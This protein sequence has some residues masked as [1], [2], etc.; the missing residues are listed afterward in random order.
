M[1]EVLEYVDITALHCKDENHLHPY[2]EQ[3]LQSPWLNQFVLVM[4][5][6]PKYHQCFHLDSA[7]Q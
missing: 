1:N 6:A 5:I 2:A 3:W 4:V 7:V